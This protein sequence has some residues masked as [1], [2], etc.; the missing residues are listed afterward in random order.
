[1]PSWLILLIQFLPQLPGI[2]SGIKHALDNAPTES[3]TT[4]QL[5]NHVKAKKFSDVCQ[6]ALCTK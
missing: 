2:I 4:E 5:D 3:M 1:M 6:G